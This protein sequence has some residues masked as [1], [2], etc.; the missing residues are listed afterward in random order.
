MKFIIDNKVHTDIAL[1]YQKLNSAI[2]DFILQDLIEFINTFNPND[3]NDFK[4]PFSKM[5]FYRAE[6]HHAILIFY[7]IIT[8]AISTRAPNSM[9]L[10]ANRR[11][12]ME[13]ERHDVDEI[14]NS[15]SDK[16][17]IHLSI[18]TA[19]PFLNAL[20]LCNMHQITLNS[21]FKDATKCLDENANVEEFIAQNNFIGLNKRHHY[22]SQ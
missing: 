22:K 8:K 5:N 1:E 12:V 18:K 7:S 10:D 6:K 20:H 19:T 4:N 3:T 9:Q 11:N 14:A 17:D 16:E 2:S 13:L 21:L 15:Q